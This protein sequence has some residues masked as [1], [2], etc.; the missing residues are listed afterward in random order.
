[1]VFFCKCFS[2][3][4]LHFM[5]ICETMKRFQQSVFP[6]KWQ[7]HAINTRQSITPYGLI[8]G[9]LSSLIAKNVY[10]QMSPQSFLIG[11]TKIINRIYHQTHLEYTYLYDYM[12]CGSPAHDHTNSITA[13]LPYVKCGVSTG[14]LFFFILVRDILLHSQTHLV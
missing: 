13:H 8:K 12:Y 1:M 2:M 9:Q 3:I 4:T 6:D 11:S 10:P 5:I 7:E 14:R